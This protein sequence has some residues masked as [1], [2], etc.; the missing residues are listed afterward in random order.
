MV[1]FGGVRKPILVVVGTDFGNGGD[2]F[3]WLD[4]WYVGDKGSL[5][6]SYHAKAVSL[7]AEDLIVGKE[8]YVSALIYLKAGK[9]VWQQQGD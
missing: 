8:G 6:K 5:Q 4:V 1:L 3:S 2:D 9:L 7:K